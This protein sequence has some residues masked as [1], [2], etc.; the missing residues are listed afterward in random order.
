MKTDKD[1]VK[2]VKCQKKTMK[3][4]DVSKYFYNYTNSL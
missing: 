2:T 1:I 4:V 3:I